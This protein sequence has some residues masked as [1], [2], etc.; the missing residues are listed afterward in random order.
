MSLA[1]VARVQAGIERVATRVPTLPVG[2]ALIL[3]TLTL[4]NRDL[5]ARMDQY[6]RP[7]GLNEVEFRTLSILFAHGAEQVCPSDLGGHLAQSPANKTRVSDALLQRGFI[8]RTPSE[9]DR[10][11]LMLQLTPEGD[12][13]ME[14]LLPQMSDFMRSLFGEFEPADLNRLMEDLKRLVAALDAAPTLID[15]RSEP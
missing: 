8:T 1:Q 6:L 2:Q 9:Q 13:L 3:R 4:L 7:A 12:A 5:V 10:R 14:R 15:D 11:R